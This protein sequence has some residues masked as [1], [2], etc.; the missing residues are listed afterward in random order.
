MNSSSSNPLKSFSCIYFR[1]LT[2]WIQ[3]AL[4]LIRIVYELELTS[5]SAAQLN[6][7]HEQ[8][9]QQIFKR[10]VKRLFV[11]YHAPSYYHLIL[12]HKRWFF[13]WNQSIN[14]RLTLAISIMQH[15]IVT[16]RA[17]FLSLLGTR[18]TLLWIRLHFS[19]SKKKAAS[20]GRYWNVLQVDKAASTD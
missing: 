12:T 18:T 5:I 3:N 4:H 13:P 7:K 17:V 2:S 9:L 11:T 1:K 14:G 19:T 15:S 20:R 16:A 8:V 10:L 6:R